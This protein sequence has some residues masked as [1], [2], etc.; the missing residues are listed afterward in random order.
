MDRLYAIKIRQSDGTYGA[1]I[2]VSVLAENVDWSSTLSLVDILGQVD[3]SESIQ[4][5]IN[6]LKN[7]R[8]T[9]ASVN[10]LDQKVDNA[11]E[12]ITHNSEIAE[13]R[14][15]A[16][17]T[18]YS[19]LKER[20]DGAYD[21]LEDGIEEN[22]SLCQQSQALISEI[23][24]DLSAETSAR[25]SAINSEVTARNSAISSAIATEV[26]NRNNA[27]SSA[28]STEVNNRNSAISSEASAR[29][30][31]DDNLQSQ[32]N[33]LVAPTG[34]APSAAEIENARIGADNKTY[35][36]LGDA[37]RTQ[38]EEVN[39]TV[40]YSITV[41]VNERNGI[42]DDFIWEL[43][44]VNTAN[45]TEL[46]RSDCVRTGFIP[47]ASKDALYMMRVDNQSHTNWYASAVYFDKN[48]NY[49][50]CY[51]PGS[52]MPSVSV[53]CIPSNA[54]A[55]VCYVRFII[56]NSQSGVDTIT[57]Y[58]NVYKM[59]VRS[60]TDAAYHSKILK[61][62]ADYDIFDLE[63]TNAGGIANGAP[64][65]ATGTS[66]RLRSVAGFAFPL[67]SKLIVPDN[68]PNLFQFSINVYYDSGRLYEIMRDGAWNDISA[69]NSFDFS[70]LTQDYYMA[71]SGK[72]GNE[73]AITSDMIEELG[74][75]VK[76]A[77]PHREKEYED[78]LGGSC[79]GAYNYFKKFTFAYNKQ[80]YVYESENN[81]IK[82]LGED[83]TTWGYQN[84]QS[85][86]TLEPG[87]YHFKVHSIENTGTYDAAVAYIIAVS[88]G[89]RLINYDA[90]YISNYDTE[91]TFTLT[92]KTIIGVQI[93]SFAGNKYSV[94][95]YKDSYDTLKMVSDK[96]K[97]IQEKY[98]D[99]I[100]DSIYSEPISTTKLKL[101]RSAENGRVVYGF[102]SDNH[103][104]SDYLENN[105]AQKRQYR[106][107]IDTL[108]G[109][110]V[111]FIV[112]GGDTIDG[113]SIENVYNITEDFF[114]Y[115]KTNG[116]PVAILNGNHDDNSYISMQSKAW[117]RSY[118]VD[119]STV[120]AVFPSDDVC[121][122]YF[123][124][125]R[126]NMRVVCLDASDYPA[127]HSGSDWWSLSQAQVEW[128]IDTILD[129]DNDIAIMT[130]MSPE[131]SRNSYALG[132][133]G[134]YHSD[135]ISVIAAFN[136]RG[137]I[138]LYGKTHN[139]SAA[140]NSIRWMHCGHSHIEYMEDY[141]V[142][143]IP[144]VNTGCGKQSNQAISTNEQRDSDGDEYTYIMT[145]AAGNEFH[146]NSYG[147]KYRHFTP[148]TIGTIN[149]S[150]FDIVSANSDAIHTYRIGI[151]VDREFSYT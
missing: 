99:P 91:R 85:Y 136:S 133:N 15:G 30:N 128:F 139:F 28:I 75:I 59:Y 37:I 38:V 89:T 81:V 67:G 97:V 48:K 71:L 118:L 111:D 9:Q 69:I 87:I 121:Y 51:A 114:G 90:R 10:A 105:M 77:I 137:S 50:G 26:T 21:K 42:F 22:K 40:N 68:V 79:V 108:S 31:A 126:K 11:V 34:E 125:D 32:I 130:H 29:A 84:A 149:E 131:Y 117:V 63:F 101:A 16:D 138:S 47:V 27:I 20:L 64:Y 135:L 44:S 129:T 60:A 12:Y 65:D 6:N 55:N 35:T 86:I 53:M 113:N 52:A 80:N 92:S 102:L 58:A 151:G 8:A 142:A 45:G 88:D 120:P 78:R 23:R 33:Q 4:D 140:T 39:E 36:S 7:T 73:A 83:Y 109:T 13:A 143:G 146:T 76:V 110:G 150:L 106:A 148:R 141:K 24:E 119:R 93:K 127:G 112:L 14:V 1:A 95:L 103:L 123:D 5:Q 82:Q 19:S 61:A 18:S 107:M 96:V 25:I 147:Y 124:I 122:Y 2:P 56:L 49:I 57:E 100:Y 98:A 3:T 94:Y 134:G 66:R 115:A 43:G 145:E 144:C 54:Y 46:T 104:N 74:R 62:S 72:T 41:A 17:D 132:D 116:I 70:S